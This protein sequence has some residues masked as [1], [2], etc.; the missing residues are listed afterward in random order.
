MSPPSVSEPL[1]DLS[2]RLFLAPVHLPPSGALRGTFAPWPSLIHLASPLWPGELK[3]LFVH[4]PWEILT[5]HRRT[6]TK[7]RKHLLT[8]KALTNTAFQMNPAPCGAK[9]GDHQAKRKAQNICLFLQI[10]ENLVVL[11]FN[12]VHSYWLATSLRSIRHGH[13]RIH[14]SNHTYTHQVWMFY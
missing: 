7:Q 1:K 12:H 3:A 11:Y 10:T 8:A 9:G 14:T 5:P 13:A 4:T 2:P 6:H